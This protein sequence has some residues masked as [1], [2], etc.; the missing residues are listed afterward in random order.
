MPGCHVSVIYATQ[1]TD[2]WLRAHPLH[3]GA[4]ASMLKT[5]FDSTHL[6]TLSVKHASSS[7]PE[8]LP[9]NASSIAPH[10]AQARPLKVPQLDSG[11]RLSLRTSGHQGTLASGHRRAALITGPIP[12]G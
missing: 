3:P 7:A 2:G 8:S 6:H 10:S 1:G 9:S 5:T 12:G 11:R 4:E